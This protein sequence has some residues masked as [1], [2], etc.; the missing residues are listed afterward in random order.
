MNDDGY[1]L[2]ANP[3]YI[4][5]S[6]PAYRADNLWTMNNFHYEWFTQEVCAHLRLENDWRTA[7]GAYCDILSRKF[8]DEKLCCPRCGAAPG[9]LHDDGCRMEVCPDCGKL[10]YVAC[11]CDHKG[12]GF[13]IPWRGEWPGKRECREFGWWA[14]RVPGVLG[15]VP[16]GPNDPGA[17]EDLNRLLEEAVWD[18]DQQRWIPLEKFTFKRILRDEPISASIW[19]W[20]IVCLRRYCRLGQL[21]VLK[22]RPKCGPLFDQYY[23]AERAYNEM[24]NSIWWA[25]WEPEQRAEWDAVCAQYN[26]L[27]Q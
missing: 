10:L 6:W 8:V 22:E 14:R 21:W 15:W 16:C 26:L 19:A 27:D 11:I 4:D 1:D 12:T 24:A 20:V 3:A 2:V 7:W 25:A 13:R 18:R 5:Q 17:A 23:E 9:T